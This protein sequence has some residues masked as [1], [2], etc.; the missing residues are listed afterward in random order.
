MTKLDDGQPS[1]VAAAEE[2][3]LDLSDLEGAGLEGVL[4]GLR[5]ATPDEPIELP[6]RRRGRSPLISLVVVVFGIYLMASMWADFS[7]WIAPRVPT[8]LGMAAEWVRDGRVPAGF[9][10]E[11]VV[12][13]GTPDVQHAARLSTKTRFIGYR[14][15]TEGGGALFAALPRGKEK[16]ITDNFEGRFEGRMRTLSSHSV[17]SWL[18]EFFDREDILRVVDASPEALQV[19]VGSGAATIETI[20]GD[21][22]LTEG[23][24]VRLVASQPESTVQLGKTSFRKVADADAAV[25]ALGHP[26]VRIERDSSVFHTYRV[27][28][29]PTERDA[30]QARLNADLDLPA[31]HA[32]PKLGALVLPRTA[33]YVVNPAEIVVADGALRFPYGDNTTS[34]GYELRDGK[35]TERPVAEGVMSVPA[36]SLTAVRVERPI[37]VDPDG[38]VINVGETPADAFRNGILW[39]LVFGI[40]LAN[41]GSVLLWWR[42]R[43]SAKS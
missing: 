40:T 3:A 26:F 24:K 22:T 7:Y 28:I 19:S 2:D 6:G 5:T 30:I 33:T 32:D 10:N 34:P 12:I 8:D 14:R 23:D 37:R 9:D 15:L 41:L 18:K 29:P 13:S 38:Y 11:Y 17:F 36:T 25:E 21:L 43:V 39:I 16:K 31:D 20:E 35:L 42:R 27:R 1:E 4:S